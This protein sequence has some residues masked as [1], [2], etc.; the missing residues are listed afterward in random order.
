MWPCSFGFINMHM[1]AFPR[2]VLGLVAVA[3]SVNSVFACS[4]I[5]I[6]LAP[7]AVKRFG[8]RISKKQALNIQSEFLKKE[9]LET[10]ADR[11]VEFFDFGL[12]AFDG[13]CEFP[14][15][16]ACDVVQGCGCERF[17]LESRGS[18]EVHIAL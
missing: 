13:T 3:I 17:D 11:A 7:C 10:I 4:D 14:I 6:F 12:E 5:K 1:Q 8:T 16:D 2:R 15:S 18:M 9:G